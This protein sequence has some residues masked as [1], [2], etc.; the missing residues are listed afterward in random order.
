LHQESVDEELQAQE[1]DLWF[2]SFSSCGH[3]A[4]LQAQKQ[5]LWFFFFALPWTFGSIAGC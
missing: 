3:V 2:S 4:R 5:D 1:Q